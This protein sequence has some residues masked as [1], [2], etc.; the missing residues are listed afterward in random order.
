MENYKIKLNVEDFVIQDE[1]KKTN[2]K[3]ITSKGDRGETGPA[4]PAGPAGVAGQDGYTPIKGVDYFTEEDIDSLHI[5]RKLSDLQNDVGYI[6]DYTET[7]P[8]FSSSAAKDITSNDI[9]NWNNKSDFSGD[10]NDLTNKPVIPDVTNY[11]TKNTTELENYTLTNDL[12]RVALT[13]NYNDL[14]NK[15]TMFSGDYNDLTN[16]PTNCK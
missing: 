1:T 10:Y 3:I 7:D 16:K 2:V 4:G 12:S 8:I 13:N 14:N 9:T 5:P 11:V 15:P 6:T